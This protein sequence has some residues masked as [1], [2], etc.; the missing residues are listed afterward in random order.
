MAKVHR[1]W[2]VL[3]HLP[4]EELSDNLW[5][6]QGSLEG[7]ALKRVMTVAKLADGGLVIHNGIALADESMAR[8]EAWGKPTWL[9]VPNVY[10]RLDAPAFKARFPDV[11]VLCPRGAV[12][13]VRDVVAVDGTYEDF[14]AGGAVQLEPLDGVGDAEGVMVVES[15]DGVTLVFNDLIFNMPHGKGV[16]GFIFRHI[17]AST[18]GPRFSRLVRMF[19]VKDKAALRANLERLAELDPI[20]IIVSHHRMITERPAEVLRAAIATL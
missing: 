6:V 18:G 8:L 13:K 9:V 2:R 14:P 20:R 5:R 10:H 11:R 7:M 16:A 15:S 3:P 12:R 1:E 4:I 17:M 19:L